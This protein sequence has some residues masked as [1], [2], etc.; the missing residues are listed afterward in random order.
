MLVLLYGMYNRACR[1]PQDEIQEEV[2]EFADDS[3]LEVRKHRSIKYAYCTEY[4][5]INLFKKT[6]MADLDKLRVNLEKLEIA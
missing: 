1:I 5:V 6:T 4:F 3:V 2:I